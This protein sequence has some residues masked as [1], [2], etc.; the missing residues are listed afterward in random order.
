VITAEPVPEPAPE[1]TAV[2]SP[3]EDEPLSREEPQAE[4]EATPRR[5]PAPRKR[6]ARSR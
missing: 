1:I 6:Q 5:K 2:E 3:A 4:A